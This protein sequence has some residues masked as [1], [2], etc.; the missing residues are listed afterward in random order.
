MKLF[1]DLGNARI[2][3]AESGPG[4]WRTGA[5]L[6]GDQPVST[7][8]DTTWRELSSPEQII[9]SSVAPVEQLRDLERWLQQ[10]WARQAHVIQSRK[11]MLGVRNTYDQPATLGTD[12]WAA[13]IA[14]H[15]L[16]KSP[17]SVVDCG[18]AVTMDAL[19]ANGEFLGGVIFPG[20][21]LLG[22]SLVQG[23]GAIR[24][25]AGSANR[26]PGQSTADAVA[27]GSHYGL[28]GAIER[29][30]QEYR[31][32]LGNNMEVLF[33][34]ADASVVM[35]NVRVGAREVPDL[36]LKGLAAIADELG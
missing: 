36:V 23:T 11:T 21:R 8:L 27:A 10:R 24:E 1:V 32:R 33:T 16:T 7:L 15:Q 18:T 28:A 2:K 35:Q 19:T 9:V 12:R 25:T 14:A 26:F 5:E 30:L 13:L 3:W 6:L 31:C 34:G 17:V 29:V 20:L 4:V 22:L